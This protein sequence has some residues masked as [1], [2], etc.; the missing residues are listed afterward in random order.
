MKKILL[1]GIIST[2]LASTMAFATAEEEY[3]EKELNAKNQ[4]T[5]FHTYSKGEVERIVE[6]EGAKILAFQTT[7][8]LGGNLTVVAGKLINP[9]YTTK[10]GVALSIVES[11]E[12][13]NELIEK[14]KNKGFNDKY[15]CPPYK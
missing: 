7:N 11:V 4:A 3:V 9:K 10:N 15:L 5:F 6:Y 1:T 2:M 12:C 8:H 13:T 14:L